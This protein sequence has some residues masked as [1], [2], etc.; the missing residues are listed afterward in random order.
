M[1]R[2]SFPGRPL[3]LAQMVER[4]P[5]DG[6]KLAEPLPM[7]AASERALEGVVRALLPPRPA[8]R[9]LELDRRVTQHV[10]RMLR[11]MLPPLAL[12]FVLLIRLLDLAPL[13]RFQAFSRL[14]KLEP[15]EGSKILQGIATSRF[16]LVRLMMLGP[17]AVVLST[18]FDQDECHKVLDYEPKGFLRERIQRRETLMAEERQLFASQ[19]PPPPVNPR[20][21]QSAEVAP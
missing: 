19:P 2:S 18:Y 3:P 15:A 4:H 9:T 6:W 5:N 17:K 11:Y 10:R 21:A 20:P 13:W 1:S 8:P 7:S 14:S 12:G 16:M